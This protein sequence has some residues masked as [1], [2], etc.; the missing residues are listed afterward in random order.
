MLNWHPAV[1]FPSPHVWV[2]AL[3]SKDPL[4]MGYVPYIVVC[5]DR[6][7]WLNRSGYVIDN[8][9]QWAYINAPVADTSL[10][11]VDSSEL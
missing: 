4:I 2:L 9:A 3:Q 1:D 10:N 5:R 7:Q 11:P 6:D 8:I